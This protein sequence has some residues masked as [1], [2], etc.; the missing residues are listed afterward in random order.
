MVPALIELSLGDGGARF[1][2]LAGDS[3]DVGDAVARA[4]RLLG[5]DV[6][7]DEPRAAL[8]G[9]ALLGPLVHRPPGPARSGGGRRHRA[10]GARCRE[11][12]GVAGGCGH[13]ARTARGGARPARTAV[14]AAPLP[15]GRPVR[16]ARPRNA[17]DAATRPRPSP[18]WGEDV[19]RSVAAGTTSTCGFG[20][21]PGARPERRCWPIP[22]IGDWTASYIALRVLGDP[23]AF[24]PTDLGI[25]RALRASDAADRRSPAELTDA[26]ARGGHMRRRCC[27]PS[28][29]SSKGRRG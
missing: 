8:V 17:P 7:I 23:D 27:G 5:L 6:S 12:A 19:R 21:R 9:D 10:R 11:P 18:I 14:A 16:R 26:G 22:G 24:L 4:R 3:R 13:G 29:A 25:K 1:R 2:M 20:A 15:Y 28:T